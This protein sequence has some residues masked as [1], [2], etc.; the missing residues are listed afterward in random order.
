VTPVLSTLPKPADGKKKGN[1]SLENLT[2]RPKKGKKADR[3][4]IP[5]LM[6]DS[7]GRPV[8]P[9][10]LGDVTLH[11]VGE[12]VPDRL[13]FHCQ[14]SIYPA[15]YCITRLYASVSKADSK[16]LYTC[17][18]SDNDD[19][20]PFFEI[21]AE[22]SSDTVYSGSS[23]NQCHVQLLEAINESRGDILPTEGRGLDFFALSHPVIQN[24]IQSC[25][26]SRK[27]S[28]YKWVKFDINK[29]ETN[30]NVAVGTSDPCVGY[31]AFKMHLIAMGQSKSQSV[32]S[33]ADPSTNLRSLLTKGHHMS[34]S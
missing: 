16:C 6:L 28:R 21:A 19:G 12:I 14:E 1:D 8:F 3:K 22:D 30:D 34:A 27:C 10:V 5:P 18:I 20:E 23:P 15:G 2:V 26:G 25:P 17:K 7:L 33:P 9:M 11:S 32:L 24:L 31:G 13:S 29:A 4:V